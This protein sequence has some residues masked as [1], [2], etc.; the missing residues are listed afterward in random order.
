[1]AREMD[2]TGTELEVKTKQSATRDENKRPTRNHLERAP[3]RGRLIRDLAAAELPQDMLAERYGC[4]ASAISLF[5]KRHLYE[6]DRVRENML[7]EYADVWV[8]KKVERLRAYQ[9]K[10]EDMLEGRSPRH[11]EVIA[12][13]LKAVAEELGDLPARQQVNVSTQ[14][15]T[16]QVVGIDPNDL[17]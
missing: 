8:A 4:S 9:Q 14:N 7:D 13:L 15:V 10:V 1:M 16:Y 6:I 11:A 17:R 3:I 2:T 5:K 12:T